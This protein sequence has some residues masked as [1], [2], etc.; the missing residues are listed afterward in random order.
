M[1]FFL[2][3]EAYG[4]GASILS[5]FLGQ[6]TELLNQSLNRK[7][8]GEEL[9]EIAIISTCMPDSDTW[10]RERSLF[11]RKDK[12]ADIRLHI[13]YKSIC[14][15]SAYRR[16]RIYQEHLIQSI[17][18]LRR[19]VSKHFDFERLISDVKEVL[20]IA[21]G[22]KAWTEKNIVSLEQVEKDDVIYSWD[23]MK[24]EKSLGRCIDS[25]TS[26]VKEI[27][28]IKISGDNFICSANDMLYVLEK[29]WVEVNEIH[30]Y[31]LIK[32]GFGSYVRIEKMNKEI[33]EDGIKLPRIKLEK[34]NIMLIS[35]SGVLLKEA[36]EG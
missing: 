34:A 27:I 15:A 24:Q 31:D 17:E 36:F 22:N 14:R 3:F 29:G 19:K 11:I 25:C 9:T 7:N 32:T 4:K 21:L 35:E 16:N 30:Q 20:N 28:E 26:N 8:Y 5:D 23:E 12:S 13:N 18:T 10:Y 1:K 6:Y 2:S 33:F